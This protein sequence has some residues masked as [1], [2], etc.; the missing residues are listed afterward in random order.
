VVVGT[1]SDCWDDDFDGSEPA[2]SS[3]DWLF[4]VESLAVDLAGNVSLGACAVTSL[5]LM[6]SNFK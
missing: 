5:S 4:V 1:P 2:A 3:S 6:H